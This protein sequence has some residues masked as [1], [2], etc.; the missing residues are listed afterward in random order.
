MT[1]EVAR[2]STRPPEFVNS[3]PIP[4]FLR[5]N[6]FVALALYAAA[7]VA[8]LAFAATVAIILRMA[9]PI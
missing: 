9:A 5:K 8:V 7:A 3:S 4:K 2:L 1:A 6:D